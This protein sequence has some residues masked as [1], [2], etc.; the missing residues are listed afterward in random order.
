M[1]WNQIVQAILS[2]WTTSRC[3]CPYYD[4]RVRVWHESF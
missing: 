1:N 2:P 3:F 4:F